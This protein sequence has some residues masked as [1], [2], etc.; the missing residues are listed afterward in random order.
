MSHPSDAD[1]L[2]TLSVMVLFTAL[3]PNPKPS[4][5]SQSLILLGGSWVVISRVISRVIRRV[6][7]R[8]TLH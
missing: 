6:I 1:A 8:V 7:S 4:R 3:T 5:D 2:E